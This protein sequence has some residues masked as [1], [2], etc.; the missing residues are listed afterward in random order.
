LPVGEI[1]HVIG[2]T[3]GWYKI[4]RADGQV[5]WVGTWLIEA[6]T[7][8][9]TNNPQQDNEPLYD[10]I[11]HPNETAIRE[12]YY[13]GI[14]SGHPDGSFKPDDPLNRAE[15]VKLLV[16][17]TVE[18]FDS[19]KSSYQKQCFPDISA[20]EWYTAYVCYA[21]ENNIVEGYPDGTFKPAN[22]I[23]KVEAVKVVLEAFKWYVG[24]PPSTFSFDDTSRKEWYAP[25]L[26]TAHNKGILEENSMKFHPSEA[27]DRGGVS[28]IIYQTMT[29]EPVEKPI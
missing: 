18:N 14:I 29:T 3:D 6:T 9:F 1:I 25:Y 11:G 5:G 16:E 21:Q 4:E 27:I 19:M 17:A 13:D 23:I 15:L 8:S 26:E 22:N 24:P 7:K 28:H 2:E 12:L 20:T 10:I